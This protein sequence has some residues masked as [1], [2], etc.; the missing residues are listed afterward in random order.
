MAAAA[1]MECRATRRL[2]ADSAAKPSTAGLETA[3]VIA[4]LGYLI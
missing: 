3:E 2:A 1:I 4:L